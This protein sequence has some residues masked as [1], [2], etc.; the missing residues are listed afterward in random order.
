MLRL[1]ELFP[2]VVNSLSGPTET[3]DMEKE[4]KKIKN[5]K[6]KEDCWGLN[7]STR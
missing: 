5:M 2:V 3:K 1:D 7:D 4:R 6:K